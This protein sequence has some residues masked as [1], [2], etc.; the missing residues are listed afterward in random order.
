MQTPH[1]ISQVLTSNTV[2]KPATPVQ[3]SKLGGQ[4]SSVLKKEVQQSK[5][6]NEKVPDKAPDSNKNAVPAEQNSFTKSAS[7]VPT[8]PNNEDSKVDGEDFKENSTEDANAI[9]T[10]MIHFVLSVNQLPPTPVNSTASLDNDLKESNSAIETATFLEPITRTTTDSYLASDTVAAPPVD[11][12]VQVSSIVQ[13]EAD[14][15][16]SQSKLKGQ[17]IQS[18]DDE[19]NIASQN[20]KVQGQTGAVTSAE[21]ENQGILTTTT[22]QLPEEH[23]NFNATTNLTI[24]TKSLDATET[25]PIQ[26]DFRPRKYS[27]QNLK[28]QESEAPKLQDQMKQ[29]ISN[30]VSKNMDL[31]ANS[32]SVESRPNILIREEKIESTTEDRSND[33][34]AKIVIPTAPLSAPLN[35]INARPSTELDS[36]ETLGGEKPIAEFKKNSLTNA[37]KLTLESKQKEISSSSTLEAKPKFSQ[38][39]DNIA[40]ISAPPE[41][42]SPV[43]ATDMLKAATS[44]SITAKIGTRNWDHAL[45]QKLVWMVAGGEQSAE[46]TLNPPDLG[47]LQVVL[48]VSDNQVDASFISA[49][50]DVREAIEA[51]APRLREMMDNAGITLTGFSVDSQASRSFNQDQSAATA[52]TPHSTSKNDKN[53]TTP[54]VAVHAP[55]RNRPTLGAVDTFV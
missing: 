30:E 51:A 3:E 46:L 4:F 17:T 27:E 23:S 12:K 43:A 8:T 52:K 20:V 33:E 24:S 18:T 34:A 47:P 21:A 6:R 48:N 39:L 13:Y 42:R 36:T 50:L 16:P 29:A 45:G 10:E 55:P 9:A 40:T 7:T 15:D 19:Q 44:E 49:H 32:I 14:F 5:T 28:Q 41:N 54:S 1:I 11:Q 26:T 37:D 38:A 22:Q 25:T 31:V 35:S 2:A 53:D